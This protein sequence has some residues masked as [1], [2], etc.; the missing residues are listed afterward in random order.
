MYSNVRLRY[1]TKLKNKEL[2]ISGQS[3]L[4]FK[5]STKK[6]NGKYVS[7]RLDLSATG[8]PPRGHYH[9]LEVKGHKAVL[10]FIEALGEQFGGPTKKEPFMEQFKALASTMGFGVIT[11]DELAK[12]KRKKA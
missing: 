6:E 9:I 3:D 5:W 7:L 8:F 4:K 12:G 1:V 11:G 10:Q 2:V